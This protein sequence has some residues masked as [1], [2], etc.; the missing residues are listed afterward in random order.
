[1]IHPTAFIDKEAEL[2]DHVQIGAYSFID[3]GVKLADYC[4]V[5][6]HTVIQGKTTIGKNTHISSFVSLGCPPQIYRDRKIETTMLDIGENNDI[7]EYCSISIG[8][9]NRATCIGANNLLMAYSHIGHDCQIGSHITLINGATL[10]GHVT[11]ED[12]AVIGS[13]TL[14]HPFCNIGMYSFTT[15][16]LR[17]RKDVLPYMLVGES[18]VTNKATNYGINVKGLHHH[19]FSNGDIKI[20]KQAYK[21]M[22]RNFSLM[23]DSLAQLGPHVAKNFHVQHLIAFIENSKQGVIR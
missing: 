13:G 18:R 2:G 12:H 3:A 7:R 16:L 9:Y 14:V 6:T 15:E 23:S 17:C 22:Y 4:T 5:G 1:M 10:A 20:L 11:V 21:I 8:T 19:N